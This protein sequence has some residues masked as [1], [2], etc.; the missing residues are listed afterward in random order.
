MVDSWAA[1]AVVVST[2][3]CAGT[4]STI[5]SWPLAQDKQETQ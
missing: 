2:D 3:C 1:E 4:V 5:R